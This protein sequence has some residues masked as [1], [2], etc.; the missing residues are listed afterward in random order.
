MYFNETVKIITLMDE[1]VIFDDIDYYSIVDEKEKIYKNNNEFLEFPSIISNVWDG[2][3]YLEDEIN[4]EPQQGCICGDCTCG[5]WDSDN[6]KEECTCDDVCRCGWEEKNEPEIKNDK[7]EKFKG[8][9][10]NE[11][12]IISDEYI[13][14]QYGEKYLDKDYIENKIKDAKLKVD[15]LK[16]LSYSFPIKGYGIV[17]RKGDTEKFEYYQTRMATQLCRLFKYENYNKIP[18][19]FVVKEL[20]KNVKDEYDDSTYIEKRLINFIIDNDNGWNMEYKFIHAFEFYDRGEDYETYT[21]DRKTVNECRGLEYADI[22]AG[23]FERLVEFVNEE[24]EWQW[25]K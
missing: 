19:N 4:Y 11:K 17:P 5:Y 16:K 13:K 21:D 6:D 8:K 2:T 15:F 14:K 25:F 10:K 7:V 20:S 12:S 23:N 22:P 9:Y 18:Y 1:T 24:I 3:D